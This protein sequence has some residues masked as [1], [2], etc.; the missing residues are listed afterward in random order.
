[1]KSLS[2]SISR[3]IITTVLSISLIYSLLIILYAWTI[4]D[5]IFNRL[6]NDEATHITEQF[7]RSGEVLPPK[8]DYMRLVK[9][10]SDLPIEIQKDYPS[11]SSKVEYQISSVKTLH[12][13]TLELGGQ[14]LFLLADVEQFEVSKDNMPNLLVWLLVIACVIS[15]IALVVSLLTA[16]KIARPLKTLASQVNT[17]NAENI[18]PDV[19]P[20]NEIGLLALNTK[21]AF[22]QLNSALDR[23]R[24]FT[25]DISHEIRTPVA[26]IQNVLSESKEEKTIR[27]NNF[28]K[29]AEAVA[30]IN[31]IT[32]ILLALARSESS[33]TE[34]VNL[35]AELESLIINQFDFL[36]AEA[37][38][39]L[40]LTLNFYSDVK[41]MCNQNLV[42]I[43][44]LNLLSNMVRHANGDN[45]DI[46]LNERQLIF[47]NQ[48]QQNTINSP[49]LSGVKG[50]QSEGLGHGLN[51][52]KRICEQSNWQL[53]IEQPPGYFI[54][55]ISFG[56][57]PSNT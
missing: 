36:L 56:N 33:Q 7:K 30:N 35:T 10:F 5:N 31:Q 52:I 9:N 12:M 28:S 45:A 3:V 20:E 49:F 2:S 24:V 17:K 25:K 19:F 37:D 51:L 44:M 39:H 26:I 46:T 41:V 55:Q 27:E 4:E 29:V 50:K 1:M 15:A 14:Q 42:S 6:V 23:E 13:T 57:T 47:K 32:S 54:V 40:E 38:K 21:N 18:E 8:A 11:N 16:K 48:T 34:V 22:T 53:S 43:L